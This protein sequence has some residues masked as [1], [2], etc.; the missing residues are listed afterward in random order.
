MLAIV[1][2]YRG[3]RSFAGLEQFPGD[4]LTSQI[5]DNGKARYRGSRMDKFLNGAFKNSLKSG[6]KATVPNG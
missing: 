4:E 2:Q 6:C 3:K 1:E 5:A